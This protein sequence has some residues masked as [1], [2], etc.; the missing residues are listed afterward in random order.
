MHT[1][2]TFQLYPKLG[3]E[4][5]NTLCTETIIGSMLWICFETGNGEELQEV[6]R[7][8]RWPTLHSK[9]LPRVQIQDWWCSTYKWGKWGIQCGSS[10]LNE[11]DWLN[12][13]TTGFKD[14]ANSNAKIRIGVY[15]TWTVWG[16]ALRR[17]PIPI[18]N[19][20]ICFLFFFWVGGWPAS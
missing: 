9:T 13:A 7:T 11:T 15:R 1:I 18:G 3:V 4:F 2:L 17:T 12:R 5:S 10:C 14:Y 6:V 16:H 19:S 8:I 20:N